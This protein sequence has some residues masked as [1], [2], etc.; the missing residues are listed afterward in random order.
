MS[1]RDSVGEHLHSAAASSFSHFT[2]NFKPG[3]TPSVTGT[4]ASLGEP[5]ESFE[6][7]SH[8]VHRSNEEAASEILG[9]TATP[10]PVSDTALD[11]NITSLPEATTSAALPVEPP[12][13]HA[14][15][16]NP[17]SAGQHLTES[18]RK[19]HEQAMQNNSLPSQPSEDHGFPSH[20]RNSDLARGVLHNPN[21]EQKGPS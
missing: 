20:I 18:P 6:D 7:A 2:C 17:L 12:S 21:R 9:G 13:S 3:H 4:A 1:S 15:T 5:P 16:H 8:P 19:T 14:A 10:R 11:L